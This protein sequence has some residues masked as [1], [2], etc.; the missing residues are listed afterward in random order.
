VAH[1][2]RH[3]KEL[4]PASRPDVAALQTEYLQLYLL[5]SLA[6]QKDVESRISSERHLRKQY[7]SVTK[8]YRGLRAQEKHT[9]TTINL[10]ALQQWSGNIDERESRD[11]FASQL[12]TLSRVIQEVTDLSEPHGGRYLQLVR[13]FEQWMRTVERVKE[14]RKELSSDA[15]RPEE[16][17]FIHPLDQAWKDEIRTLN[18]KVELCLRELQSLGIGKLQDTEQLADSAL[19]RIAKGHEGI[20]AMMVDELKAMQKI[21]VEVV[22]LE[23]LWIA[24]AA[25]QLRSV[26]D[27]NRVRNTRRGAWNQS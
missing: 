15:V 1:P 14:S 16:P 2:E 17:A 5:R 3:Q 22:N 25:D 13:T 7:D 9:Q 24:H 10:T 19:F 20:L 27:E 6:A 8:A 4:T 23:S 26:D 18:A 12:Q 11:S 21:E